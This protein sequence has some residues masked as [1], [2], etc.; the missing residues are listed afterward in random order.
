MRDIVLFDILFRG[1][2]RILGDCDGGLLVLTTAN[3]VIVIFLEI[4]F[5]LAMLVIVIPLA[6]IL[7]KM[8]SISSPRS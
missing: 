1:L 8:N 5:L 4:V 6:I 7:A 2:L 3:F